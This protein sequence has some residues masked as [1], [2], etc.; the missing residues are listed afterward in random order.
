MNRVQVFEC[1]TPPTCSQTQIFD[2]SEVEIPEDFAL[3]EVLMVKASAVLEFPIGALVKGDAVPEYA[4]DTTDLDGDWTFPDGVPELDLT[5]ANGVLASVMAV[6]SGALGSDCRGVEVV[7][8]SGADVSVAPLEFARLGTAAEEM[9]IT[10]QDAQGRKIPQLG[11]R[12]LKLE[13]E[14]KDGNMVA[15]REKFCMARVSSFILSLGRLLRGGWTLGHDDDGPYVEQAGRKLPIKMRRN[16]LVMAAAV[17]M[18]SALDSGRPL[19]LEAE[20]VIHQPGWSILPSGLPLLVVHRTTEVPRESSIWNADD[21]C[22]VAIFVKKDPH[23]GPPKRGDVWV[24][25]ATL[26]AEEYEASPVTLTELEG[27][28]GGF[29]DV[30]VLFHVDDLRPNLLSEPGDIFAESDLVMPMEEEAHEGDGPP[31]GGVGDIW[32]NEEDA[33]DPPQLLAKSCLKECR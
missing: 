18:I 20:N 21:W 26:T 5:R 27:E 16:T 29:R 14:S 24:Q 11:T 9:G 30:A 25:L 1:H 6:R 32:A 19:P 23:K 13:V 33:G 28:L 3:P 2:I 7:V 8:D 17:S 15:I 10:M 22:S 4:M 12:L 31:G